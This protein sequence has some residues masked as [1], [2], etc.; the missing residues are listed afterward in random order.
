[1]K[2]DFSRWYFEADDNFSGV[3]HQQGRVLLDSDWNSQTRV[4]NNWE[5]TAGKDIIGSHVAAVPSNLPEGFKIKSAKVENN[6]VKLIIGPGR[7][8]ADG[9]LTYLNG[10]ADV[11]RIAKYLKPPVQEPPFDESTIGQNTRDAVIL[12][13]WRESINGFQLPG[14]LIEPA[15]GGPDT[16]ERI[17]TAVAF[18]LFRLENAGDT[19]ES[20]V[21]K[22]QDNFDNKGK[23]KATL[24]PANIVPGDCPVVEE[25]GYTG[26][27]HNLFRIEIAPVDT[28]K[29]MFKWSRFN[30]AIVGRGIFDASTKKVDI[31]ANLQAISSSGLSDCYIEV[32]QFNPAVPGNNGL[33]H[34]EVTYGANATINNNGEIELTDPPLFGNIPA[35][36]D[37]VFFRLWNGIR[38]ISEF[39]AGA[40]PKILI[41]GIRLEF[42]AAS[43]ANYIPG[44]YWTFP[45]RA[46]EI[47]NK[48]ILIDHQPPQGIQH[49]RVPLAILNWNNAKDISYSN[50][51]IDDCRRIFQ[52]LT[53]LNTCCS[54]R[55]GD[56][57]QSFGDFNSI[58]EAIE[59]LPSAGGEVCLL[60]GIY[61]ENIV[62]SGKSNIKIHGCGTRSRIIS[63]DPKGE[64]GI[65]DPV[66][67]ITNSTDI[68]IENAAIQAHDTGIGI[69]IDEAARDQFRRIR[70]LQVS[71]IF[72]SKLT[73]SAAARSAI[74]THSGKYITIT[75]CS[76]LMKDVPGSFPGIYFTGDNSLIENNTIRVAPVRVVEFA[77][78]AVSVSAAL[79]GLQLAGTCENI[80]V[81]NN[82]IEG[83][84]GN[85][86]TLGSIIELTVDG[87]E[88]GRFF[89]WVI[90]ID[91]PCNPCKPGTSYI[92]PKRPTETDNTIQVSAGALY[93]IYIKKNI[94]TN[95]GL[96]GIGVIG[97]FDLSGTDEFI[98]VDHLTIEKNEITNCLWRSLDPVPEDMI[99]SMGYGG[100]SL[101][102]VEYLSVL[103]N[104]IENNGPNHLE[105]VC[106][107]FVLHGEGIEISG[108][109]IMNNGAK[110][111]QSPREAKDGRRGGI[112]IVFSSA[113]LGTVNIREKLYP[114]QNGFPAVQIHNNIV[115]VPL[116]QALSLTA[117]GPVSVT[118]NQF[119]SQGMVLKLKPLSPTFIASTI[120]I[121]NLG[122]SNEFYWELMAFT[123]LR[124]GHTSKDPGA[125]VSNG[126]VVIPQKGIDDLR[127]GRYLANGNV[128]FNNNQCVLDL[129]ETGVSLSLSSIFIFSLDDVGFHNNQCDC[130]L[131]DDIV[132][133]QAVAM[134]LSVRMSDNRFKEGIYNSIYSAVTMGLMNATTNNQ[135]THCLLVSGLATEKV[136][137]GNKV[138]LQISG[139]EKYC[140]QFNIIRDTNTT[141][142]TVNYQARTA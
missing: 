106:G 2:G 97:F 133:M 125:A 132:L 65:A 72:L 108:N 77:L 35:G 98:S 70:A 38:E 19:C 96:N 120:M 74:E 90:N 99:N 5:D 121:M 95:M 14:K 30:G 114:E 80:K 75:G 116:G 138:L 78:S 140:G 117:L 87:K 113:A 29:T 82:L 79:G 11:I 37:A 36:S 24:Q 109:R 142:G 21:D 39:P 58:Q 84:I 7:L 137:S 110:T 34:W 118:G 48:Q 15:L 61:Q 88:T 28:G 85:G 45:V 52:P 135:S 32:V 86:I 51:E 131:L 105:P 100:I 42:D 69:L 128:L 136:D 91:D 66:I 60:P 67:H 127:I 81:I 57:M 8:W 111:N 13:V 47:K 40:N 12:E 49:S 44:D 54:Y 43:G 41:D 129:I 18:K 62:I 101:A 123:A 63:K 124:A 1:M 115:S 92:P 89:G 126:T 134:A 22:I 59:H 122:I 103:D 83:G 25:G 73:I 46:G 130:N 64:F 16:T 33:G 26:F 112:N 93:D 68:K 141:F 53:R 23:L 3:L 104:L 71:N 9:L 17:Y 56:G 139:D 50:K 31:T 4:I 76:I 10:S 6:K 102:D 20:I 55:V 94:I 107:I 27:E 119:T